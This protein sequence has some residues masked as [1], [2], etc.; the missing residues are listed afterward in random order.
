VDTVPMPQI[1]DPDR[2]RLP[3]REHM[4]VHEHRD[5]AERYHQELKVTCS[6]G[7][8][9]WAKLT[10]VREYL[11]AHTPAADAGDS[12]WSAWSALYGSVTSALA[13]ANGDN[14]FGAQEAELIEQEQR[15]TG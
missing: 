5:R 2:L 7:Q 13:S 15:T 6:Y 14:G 9:L 3:D 4:T 8:Q 1:L 10:E 11:A 12:D